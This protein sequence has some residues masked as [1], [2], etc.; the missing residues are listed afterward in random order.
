MKKFVVILSAVLV[1]L[2]V[3]LLVAP[4]FV[5]WSKYKQQI[6]TQLH[7]AT[8]HNY[9]VN[10][11]LELA[12]IP[13]P[14]VLIEDLSVSSPSVVGGDALVSLEK[15]E[16]SVALW[17]LLSGNVVV[18]R[19]LLVEPNV[20]L[21]IAV[22]GTP[23]W[24]TPE[25]KNKLKQDKTQAVSK[26]EESGFMESISL[27]EIKIKGG[28]FQYQDKRSG[29]SVS[30]ADIY[31][32]L[33]GESLF[34]PYN[35]EGH[36]VYNGE[37]AEIE[38]KSGRIGKGADSVAIQAVLDI[39]S[40]GSSLNYSGV[41]GLGKA[42]EVQGEAG[43]K[44]ENLADLMGFAGKQASPYL[45]K[46]FKA[47]GILT[48]TSQAVAYRNMTLSFAGGEAT[49]HAILKNAV[50][51]TPLDVDLKL[52][53]IEE[54][55]LEAFLPESSPSGKMTKGI[56]SFL[57]ETIT[58]PVNFTGTA[59]LAF[60]AL[61][62]G[63]TTF[64]DV[65]VS[66]SKKKDK[67]V[68]AQFNTGLPG[69]GKIELS[70]D[71]SFAALSRSEQDKTLTLSDPRLAF[72]TTIQ[73]EEPLK[74]AL[75]FVSQDKLQ[76][77]SALLF[78][79][80]NLFAE[81]AVKPKEIVVKD[82]VVKVN[83]TQFSLN[84]A[85]QLRASNGRNLLRVA[86]GSDGMDV[87]S[88]LA[89][90]AASQGKATAH[91]DKTP[92]ISALSE[93][94]RLPFD[95]SLTM[96]LKNLHLK[97]MDFQA[98]N[99]KGKLLYNKLN[100]QTLE[101]L[102]GQGNN[103]LIAGTVGSVPGLQS[104]D[105]S[106]QGTTKDLKGLLEGF[107]VDTSGISKKVG[108]AEIISEFK[109]QAEKLSFTA[110]LKAMKGTLES[111]GIIT[112]I[113]HAPTVSG[114]TVRLK[115]P[116]YVELARIYNPSFKSG[117]AIKKNLDF[118]ASMKRDAD[119]YTLS[120]LQAN[121]GPVVFTGELSA[122]MAGEKPDITAKLQ[123]NDVPLGQLAGHGN[124]RKGTVRAQSRQ[125]RQDVRWSRNAINT[126]WMHN[127]NLA[128][129]ATAKSL[130]YGPWVLDN[131]AVDI[132][133]RDGVLAI[134]QID[135]AFNSGHIALTGKIKSSPKP[136]QPLSIEAKS[137]L[138][139]VSLES[140]VKAFSGA[141]LLKA[142]GAMS[143][144]TD[145]ETTGLSPAALIFD[146]HG[147][148]SASGTNL[149]FDGFDLAR[150]SRTLLRPSSSMSENF[151]NLLDS[152][153]GGGSTAFESLTS[154]F[155]INEGVVNFSELNLSGADAVIDTTGN[156]NLPL[157]TV[158]LASAIKLTEPADA[159]SLKAVFKG[160]LDRPGQTFGKSAMDSYFNQ[161]FG[162]TLENMLLNTLQKKKAPAQQQQPAQQANP[163][164]QQQPQQQQ[165]PREPSPEEALFGIMQ[166]I[167]G[168]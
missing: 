22:D 18:N 106:M 6:I 136:R 138:Q 152:S 104:I 88:W 27:N 36:F 123:M 62:H 140:F 25:L 165:K 66:L 157:W 52:E 10:G 85:Y 55:S 145:I 129:T 7:Q 93:K 102:D 2:V 78:D 9:E 112:D 122:D 87:D 147:K 12:L 80:V 164:T 51:D 109:G 34:G 45:K 70:A 143:M 8:G 54:L 99:L 118:F 139:D 79:K 13:F 159:P 110:N 151:G 38:L 81:G 50:K 33:Q 46:P 148:G 41:V 153:M 16:V 63:D 89:Q 108:G 128:M 115:H 4:G 72:K 49:G 11:A 60:A 71:L 23:S 30:L 103:L 82:S 83:K 74:L 105:L 114:L 160:P 155:T 28:S 61:R 101:L 97:G 154:S 53:V 116:N 31:L 135:G 91:A 127:V 77:V 75:A 125:Q 68:E 44:T 144:E 43:I 37:K 121:V 162:K 20:H 39:A 64:N 163:Q 35:A 32:A 158:D 100:L 130:S 120:E 96:A 76:P 1:F 65:T 40:S 56:Q 94:M 92:D 132:D 134:N 86:A 149:V 146:L 17:P 95:L 59:A 48:A 67:A 107:N 168:Q 73:V 29:G 124:K 167:L 161:M 90:I 57:P 137:I 21:D 26:E 131:A 58:L 111:T 156:V 15:V 47:A 141:R 117:V 113:L 166:G 84:G 133:L 42:W 150:L 142:K 119:I 126:A 69:S 3:A 24:M 5:D 19:V 98:F 14:R